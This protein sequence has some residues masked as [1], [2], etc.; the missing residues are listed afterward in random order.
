MVLHL[1]DNENPKSKQTLC[2][3]ILY[4]PDQRGKSNEFDSTASFVVSPNE[5]D[6]KQILEALA[7]LKLEL[8]PEAL[9]Y[10]NITKGAITK[11][12]ANCFDVIQFYKLAKVSLN[13]LSQA[14]CNNITQ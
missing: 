14:V 5:D 1:K 4:I 2:I 3:R 13:A 7:R 11:P 10:V 9:S 8:S 12:A 6:K